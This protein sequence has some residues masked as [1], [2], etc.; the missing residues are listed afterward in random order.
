MR[1]KFFIIRG[2]MWFM[3]FTPNGEPSCITTD[4]SLLDGLDEDD[5]SNYR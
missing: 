1:R 3:C 4:A 5:A 2:V